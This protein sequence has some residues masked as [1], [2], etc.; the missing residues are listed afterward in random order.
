VSAPPIWEPAT[1]RELLAIAA[2]SAE[3]RAVLATPEEAELFRFAIYNFRRTQGI[4][5]DMTITLEGN[6]V[7][8]RKR[9]EPSVTILHEQ[10][11]A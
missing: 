8:V 5:N 6:A 1:I 2:T 9:P 7:V 10:T 3:A 4:G 11:E